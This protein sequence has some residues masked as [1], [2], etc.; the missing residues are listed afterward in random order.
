MTSPK[1]YTVTSRNVP[2]SVTHITVEQNGFAG[3]DSVIVDRDIP[4]KTSEAG[5]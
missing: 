3:S 5:S 2:I 1:Q 4:W